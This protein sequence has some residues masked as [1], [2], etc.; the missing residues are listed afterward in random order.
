MRQILAFGEITDGRLFGEKMR[1]CARVLTIQEVQGISIN[2]IQV[3]ITRDQLNDKEVLPSLLVIDDG[4]ATSLI[5]HL[6]IYRNYKNDND[7]RG[8]INSTTTPPQ[9]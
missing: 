6:W 7:S 5:F 4:Y 1:G 9:I 3:T 8:S 2:Y